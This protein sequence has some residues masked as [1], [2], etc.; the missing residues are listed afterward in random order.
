[1]RTVLRMAEAGDDQRALRR[2]LAPRLGQ[3][4]TPLELIAEEVLGEEDGVI[5]WIAAAPDGR[6]FVV[7]VTSAHAGAAL[8]QAGLVQRAWVQAR[9]A[10]WRKLAPG[11]VVRE[12]P[13]ARAL[14]I[15]R[16][17]DRATRI[18]AREAAGDGIVLARWRIEGAAG[19]V[20]LEALEPARGVVRSAPAPRQEHNAM[21][22]TGLRETDFAN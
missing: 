1:M 9:I 10:D 5:D 2:A 22:R 18:A 3:L 13:A 6:A 14:L 17:F 16:D 11:L 4:G 8:L 7:L 15:A 20:E 12:Q 19:L 21:F